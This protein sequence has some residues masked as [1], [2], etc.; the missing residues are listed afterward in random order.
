[1]F[2]SLILGIAEHNFLLFAISPPARTMEGPRLVSQ[3]IPFFKKNS[4]ICI[5]GG[6]D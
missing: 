1:M 3:R 6:K 5:L 4:F 2:L